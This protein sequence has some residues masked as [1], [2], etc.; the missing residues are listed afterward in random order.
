MYPQHSGDVLSKN[1]KYW[2]KR[3]FW[4]YLKGMKDKCYTLKVEAVGSTKHRQIATRLHVA[5]SQMID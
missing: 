5:A 1:C 2:K 4:R 3:R